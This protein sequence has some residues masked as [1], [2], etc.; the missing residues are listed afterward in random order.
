MCTLLEPQNKISSC[1]LKSFPTQSVTKLIAIFLTFDRKPI[2]LRIIP[3]LLKPL[4]GLVYHI[5]TNDNVLYKCFYIANH[6]RYFSVTIRNYWMRVCLCVYCPRPERYIVCYSQA[7]FAL[8][9]FFYF[10]FAQVFLND[11]NSNL[12][13]VMLLTLSVYARL[14]G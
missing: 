11:E 10:R 9:L 7:A 6:T 1:S 14:H 12:V 8:S 13:S 2:P 5:I 4:A 3:H